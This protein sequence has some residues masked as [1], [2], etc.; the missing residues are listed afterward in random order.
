MLLRIGNVSDHLFS[1]CSTTHSTNLISISRTSRS[2]VSLWLVLTGL[3]DTENMLRGCD[4]DFYPRTMDLCMYCDFLYG[5]GSKPT[6]WPCQSNQRNTDWYW[7][8]VDSDKRGLIAWVLY[9]DW[10]VE[11]YCFVRRFER[12]DFLNENK[13]NFF[14]LKMSARL[15]ELNTPFKIIQW[16]LIIL[17]WNQY[18]WKLKFFSIKKQIFTTL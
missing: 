7:I 18:L 8:I 9:V 1:V 3:G 2:S 11:D 16:L 13:I 14:W 10:S 5:F 4:N 6:W 17:R 12:K 15:L